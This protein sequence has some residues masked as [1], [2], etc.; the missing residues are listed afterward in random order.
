MNVV[1]IDELLDELEACEG[2]K[3]IDN[4]SINRVYLSNIFL[5][6]LTN[7]PKPVYEEIDKGM[8]MPTNNNVEE[9]KSAQSITVGF[10]KLDESVDLDD[11]SDSELEAYLNAQSDLAEETEAN[12]ES[13][14]CTASQEN[15]AGEYVTLAFPAK[16]I[17]VSPTFPIDD[18]VKQSVSAES[19]FQEEEVLHS[20]NGCD[21]ETETKLTREGSYDDFPAILDSIPA[22]TSVDEL[23]DFSPKVLANNKTTE[24]P[25]D[26]N[27][28]ALSDANNPEETESTTESVAQAPIGDTEEI[29]V[30]MD[31]EVSQPSEEVVDVV[32]MKYIIIIGGL[33]LLIIKSPRCDSSRRSASSSG[34]FTG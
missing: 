25:E 7:P 15:D 12:G 23:M 14:I 34:C 2:D 6:D 13:L 31:V 20:S 4:T 28:F 30:H 1:D 17:S 10:P 8:L 32:G 27:P 16:L 29:Q 5:A 9:N 3:F 11:I 18:S 21:Q 26:L 33:V 24:Y 22:E 19:D